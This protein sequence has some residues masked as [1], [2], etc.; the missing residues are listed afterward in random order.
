M[1]E[2]VRTRTY[3]KY[4]PYLYDTTL[5]LGTHPAALTVSETDSKTWGSSPH[6]SL[7]STEIVWSSCPLRAYALNDNQ[8]RHIGPFTYVEKT[9][10]SEYSAIKFDQ[11]LNY[12]SKTDCTAFTAPTAPMTM[13][14]A[15]D[16]SA[17]FTSAFCNLV[18]FDF[19]AI[20]DLNIK[21]GYT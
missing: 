10:K 7:G 14:K 13:P 1:L 17:N 6:L 11:T 15:A 4:V 9:T 21:A 18:G 19:L 2:V 8:D 16:V 5:E 3:Y 20:A 12:F